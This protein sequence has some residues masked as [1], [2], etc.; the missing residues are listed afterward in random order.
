MSIKSKLILALSLI[1]V[2]T[3]L[4]TSVVN[5]A[6]TRN[7]IRNEL[8][9]SSL[10]L[11]GKNIY[12]E[13]QGA[14]IRPILASSS[15]AHDTFLKSWVRDGERDTE[16]VRRYLDEIK[17]K[18]G[19]LTAFFVSNGSD[20]YYNEKGIMKEVSPRD[21][22]DVWFY[23]FT[24]TGR[25]YRLNVD[26]SEAYN[27]TM[28]IFV[29]SRV[30]DEN[31]H[32]LGVTGAGVDIG[33]I[34]N[35]LKQ[36]QKKYARNIYLVDQDGVVQ[37][38]QDPS[39]IE[40]FSIAKAGG[41]HNVSESILNERDT[42]TA[43]E[44]DWEGE[45]HLLSSLYIPELDWF[46]IVEQDEASALT[47]AKRNLIRTLAIGS[48]VSLLVV[49]L[50]MVTVNRYQGRLEEL[51]QTDP[52]TGAANRRALEE[53][54]DQAAYKA[55]RYGTPFSTIII[56]LDK[57]KEINDSYGHIQ[58]DSVLKQVADTIAGTIRPSDLL[59]RWGGDEFIILLD[60]ET[61]DARSLAER[62]LSAVA[63]APDKPAVSFSYGLA[64]Y[65]K[66]DDLDSITM[67]ADKELYQAKGRA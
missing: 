26:P 56:D 24:R 15:M 14:M 5:Y 57:F 27:D 13:I 17:R 11:M 25:E 37:V 65:K 52:L 62:I 32:L 58:G 66:G 10:P 39:L 16:K 42:V 23:A 19:F 49:L 48:G 44:Y 40:R 6:V 53:R 59:A 36:I 1:L 67:R 35:R 8:L 41:I 7:S 38:H 12:S 9:H 31:R 61:D 20:R 64:E 63:Q 28:T 3:F 60:G 2:T 30:E 47:P 4:G 43:L 55:E 18:Y 54:F 50:C 33:Y 46:L 21:P 29:N 22:R 34:L 51:A 45:H